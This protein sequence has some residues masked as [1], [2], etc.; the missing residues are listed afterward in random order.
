[1]PTLSVPPHLIQYIASP[2][3]SQYHAA[4]A[5]EEWIWQRRSKG[6][7]L[8]EVSVGLLDLED[9]VR[10]MLCH[11]NVGANEISSLRQGTSPRPHPAT[12][13]VDTA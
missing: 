13:R 4:E 1:M 11:T 5:L 10:R 7:S 8:F 6:D 2:Q 9:R 3:T 12:H